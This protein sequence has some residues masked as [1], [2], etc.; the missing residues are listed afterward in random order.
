VALVTGEND[1][2]EKTGGVGDVQEGTIPE[3]A[4]KAT[5]DPRTL[6][7]A[8]ARRCFIWSRLLTNDEEAQNANGNLKRS[9]LDYFDFLEAF[10]LVAHILETDVDGVVDGVADSAVVVA[11]ELASASEAGAVSNVHK[12]GKPGAAT[13]TTPPVKLAADVSVLAARL[14]RVTGCY[15]RLADDDEGEG[16]TGDV[17]QC[18]AWI[19]DMSKVPAGSKK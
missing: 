4:K 12:S 9:T 7:I 10:A 3:K 17:E 11:S 5:K 14:R 15:Q 2:G 19:E 16:E 1:D 6:T 13:T 18:A 8:D